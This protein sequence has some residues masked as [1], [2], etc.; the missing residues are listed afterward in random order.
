MRRT[1]GKH[2]NTP[3]PNFQAVRSVQ[4]SRSHRSNAQAALPLTHTPT[5]P[6]GFYIWPTKV[7]L[8][9]GSPY[10]YN[11]PE[12]LNVL[13]QFADIMTSRGLGHGFYYSLTNN[14]YLDVFGHYVRNSTLLPG[15]QRVTQAEFEAIALASVTE[16]WTLFG[17]LTEIWFDGGYTS[18]MEAAITTLLNANQPDAI[19]MNGGGVSPNPLRWSGTEGYKPPNWPNLYVTCDD[20]PPPAHKPKRTPLSQAPP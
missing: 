19:A 8:P 11:V 17:N 6:V 12:D 4:R 1:G 18:D 2:T 16:L 5:P 7:T 3:N 15:Q 9:D 10:G 13:Q 14:F 20:F